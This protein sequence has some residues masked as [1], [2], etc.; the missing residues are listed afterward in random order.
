MD[1]QSLNPHT[2][3]AKGLSAEYWAAEYLQNKGY[4]VLHRRYK[5]LYG[6]L[7][8]IVHQGEVL[9]F[10]EV[11]QRPKVDQGLYALTPHQQKRLWQTGEYFLQNS[12]Y[13]VSWCTIRFDLVVVAVCP[14]LK[15]RNISHIENL[16][17]QH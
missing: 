11:K 10:V 9:S 6:E 5:T 13:E 12:A 8:L 2:S 4:T 1:P 17:G 16:L 3:Y 15:N 14:I 7:D